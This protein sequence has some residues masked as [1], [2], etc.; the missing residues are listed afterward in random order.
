MRALKASCL[1]AELVAKSK[2][3]HSVGESFILPACKAIVDEMLRPDAQIAK[4][5]LG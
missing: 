5:P 1:V 3:P 4:V 2:K